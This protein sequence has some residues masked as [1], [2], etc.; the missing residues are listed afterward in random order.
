MLFS[1][2]SVPVA[3]A[4]GVDA[5]RCAELRDLFEEIAVR[6]KEVGDA[7]RKRID[8]HPAFHA[9][10]DIGEAVAE[11]KR[12]LLCGGR[13]GF[14]NVVTA[15]RDRVPERHLFGTERNHVDDDAHVRARRK[16]PFLLRNVFFEDIGL[17]RAAEFRAWDALLLRRSDVLRKR[18]RRG[19]VDR[20]RRRDVAHVDAFKQLLHIGER[21]DGDA[22][23]ADLAT[24]LRRIGVVT[25][26]GRHIEGNREAVL[27][28]L[29]E[30][31]ITL[32]RLFGVAEAG[33]LTHRP[34]AITITT[35]VNAAR[36]R[37]DARLAEITLDVEVGGIFGA[38]DPL[39]RDIRKG[40]VDGTAPGSATFRRARRGGGLLHHFGHISTYA[41]RQVRPRAPATC[42]AGASRPRRLG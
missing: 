7:R 29:E 4:L 2:R 3:H 39:E 24:R 40:S 36:V 33:K 17:H 12:E 32:V 18:N 37:K 22:T 26:E 16:D 31:V 8:I 21:V 30:K 10:L 41:L 35:R 6:V 38:V 11:S 5:A 1:G 34:K 19:A 13:T 14:A 28:L 9:G 27:A 15:H 23:L 20:H 42:V 25:H